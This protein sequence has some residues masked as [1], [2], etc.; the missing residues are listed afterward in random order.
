[1]TLRTRSD[2][3]SASPL[4]VCKVAFDFI[5][6]SSAVFSEDDSEAVNSLSMTDVSIVSTAADGDLSIQEA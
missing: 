1:M 2:G 3:D 4:R 5:S 6:A